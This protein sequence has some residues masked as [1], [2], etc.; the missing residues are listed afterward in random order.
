MSDQS[1]SIELSVQVNASAEAVWKALTDAEELSRWFPPEARVRPGVGGSIWLSWGGGVEGEAA[2]EVWE[3]NRH[4]RAGEPSGIVV[5][6]F[7][8][9]AGSATVLRVVH[10]GFGADAAWDDAYEGA[11]LGWSYFLFNLRFYLERHAGE[12]RRMISVRQPMSVTREEAWRV[13]QGADGLA[14]QPPDA[15]VDQSYSINLGGRRWSGKV[16][17]LNPARGFAGTIAELNDGLIFI[18]L[19]PGGESWNCGVWLSVYGTVPQAAGLQ[20]ALQSLMNELFSPGARL[21]S[22]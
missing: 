8:E 18:E 12:P 20:E 11:K 5:D 19:E 9:K 7:I 22:R 6:Y 16:V 1:R 21:A 15:A 4:L 14:L 10:S 3:P 2:I 17:L 13:L